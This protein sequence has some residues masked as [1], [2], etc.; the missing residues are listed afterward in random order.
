ML[1]DGD[2]LCM[3]TGQFVDGSGKYLSLRPFQRAL[4]NALVRLGCGQLTPFGSRSDGRDQQGFGHD[5]RRAHISAYDLA[6]R[7]LAEQGLL[8]DTQADTL[9]AL[10][11]ALG[12]A[13]RD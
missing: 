2:D 9:R 6:V 1:V 12:S 7:T 13:R 10:A 8:T 4:V 3:L 11:G 5:E